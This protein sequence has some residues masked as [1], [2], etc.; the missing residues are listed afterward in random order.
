MDP[1]VFFLYSVPNPTS[2]IGMLATF[3][4]NIQTELKLVVSGLALV[5]VIVLVA[6]T[7]K[8]QQE[9]T[10]SWGRVIGGLLGIA[11]LWF[12]GFNAND[13]LCWILQASGQACP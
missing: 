4:S 9:G 3:L 8:Q 5:A 6:V 13:I 7:I 1:Q 11:F 12:I 2:P 10:A